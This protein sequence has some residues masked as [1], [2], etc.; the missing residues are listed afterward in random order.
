M[1]ALETAIGVLKDQGERGTVQPNGH[2]GV[3]ISEMGGVT[4]CPQHEDVKVLLSSWKGLVMSQLCGE[5]GKPIDLPVMPLGWRLV[6]AK[7]K[8]RQRSRNGRK[9]KTSGLP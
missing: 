6:R 5:C 3:S 4:G 7:K 2:H 8:T 1:Q 9:R